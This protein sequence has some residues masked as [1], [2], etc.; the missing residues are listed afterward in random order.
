MA[1]MHTWSRDR[2]KARV[3][4]HGADNEAR[5][6]LIALEEPRPDEDDGRVSPDLAGLATIAEGDAR[7]LRTWLEAHAEQPPLEERLGTFEWAVRELT[8]LREAA[9]GT[10]DAPPLYVEEDESAPFEIDAGGAKCAHVCATCG[11][12]IDVIE[13][14]ECGGCAAK[15]RE[16]IREEIAERVRALDEA[17]DAKHERVSALRDLIAMRDMTIKNLESQLAARTR[18]LTAA[19]DLVSRIAVERDAAQ[20]DLAN[21]REAL[22]GRITA[23]EKV[24]ERLR[25]E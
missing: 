14:V 12:L 10:R 22:G 6:M 18:E 16:Q 19:S 20:A 1:M 4:A 15:A 7:A 24:N 8:R 23:L 17:R 2:V 9:T 11:K 13:V 25:A 3:A 5:T 21:E